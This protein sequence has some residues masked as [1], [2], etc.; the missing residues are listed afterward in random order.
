MRTGEPCLYGE[1]E[2]NSYLENKLNL[3]LPY[4][5]RD[6]IHLL[7]FG[8][9]SRL[10]S[11]SLSSIALFRS[12]LYISVDAITRSILEGGVYLYGVQRVNDPLM[13]AQNLLEYIPDT[14]MPLNSNDPVRLP[15][16]TRGQTTHVV[17]HDGS[18]Y[19]DQ[20]NNFVEA[21]LGFLLRELNKRFN[22]IHQ[23]YQ[24]LSSAAHIDGTLQSQIWLDTDTDTGR[25]P[26]TITSYRK[27]ALAN[28]TFTEER[29]VVAR[30]ESACIFTAAMIDEA[31]ARFSP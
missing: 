14:S 29:R 4:D 8:V 15:R 18:P 22:G 10:E 20:R 3:I 19:R 16:R 25:S 13:Y 12:R 17:N 28:I 9:L 1:D 26:P 11:A 6:P 31:I 2:F 24:I 27:G 21:N 7:V 23:T 30:F 5:A